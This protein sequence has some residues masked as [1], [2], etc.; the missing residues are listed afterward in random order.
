VLF[1]EDALVVMF[2]V[3]DTALAEGMVTR[4]DCI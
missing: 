2:F 3:T 1:E 4:R